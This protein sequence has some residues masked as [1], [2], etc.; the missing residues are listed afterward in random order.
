MLYADF[1]EDPETWALLAVG[2]SLAVRNEAVGASA[3]AAANPQPPVGVRPG[4]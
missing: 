3:V 4:S 2:V 1:L